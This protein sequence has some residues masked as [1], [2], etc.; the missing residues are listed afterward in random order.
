MLFR[1]I[2]PSILSVNLTWRSRYFLQEYITFRVFE[3]SAIARN[4]DEIRSS[5]FS[6]MA[7]EKRDD[8]GGD[9]SDLVFACRG[10]TQRSINSET[11]ERWD[12]PS[13]TG[14]GSCR[15][16]KR[17]KRERVEVTEGGLQRKGGTAEEP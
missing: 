4:S 1:S 5:T 11:N 13:Y 15:N 3:I 8:F 17:R 6:L 14:M 12:A 16:E 7:A 10:K 2:L 9:G